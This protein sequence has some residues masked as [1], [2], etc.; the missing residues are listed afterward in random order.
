M[1]EVKINKGV[2]DISGHANYAEPGKDIVCAAF[3][4]LVQNLYW[5]IN[6]FTD[7]Y[8]SAAADEG[9]IKRLEFMTFSDSAKT[10][11]NSFLLGI[12]ALAD[13]YPENINIVIEEAPF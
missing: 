2:I 13:N 11:L 4:A 9:Q 8:I 12:S 3:S 10:L 7:D 5:G 1:I 6:D